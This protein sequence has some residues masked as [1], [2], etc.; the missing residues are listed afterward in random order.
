ME[1][2]EY[3]VQWLKWAKNCIRPF[4]DAQSW[5]LLLPERCS[6]IFYGEEVDASSVSVIHTTELSAQWDSDRVTWVPVER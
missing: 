2:I 1:S 4:R 3:I 5:L 6:A